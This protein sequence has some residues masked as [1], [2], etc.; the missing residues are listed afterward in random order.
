[1]CHGNLGYRLLNYSCGCIYIDPFLNGLNDNPLLSEA[2][3]LLTMA[4]M[5]YIY[6]LVI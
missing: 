1:M 2:T 3:H 4:N 6:P 5:K